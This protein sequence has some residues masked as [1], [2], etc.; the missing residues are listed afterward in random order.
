MRGL[1]DDFCVFQKSN[2]E[3]GENPRVAPVAQLDRAADYGSA[4]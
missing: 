3:Q 4:G 1:R 2:G